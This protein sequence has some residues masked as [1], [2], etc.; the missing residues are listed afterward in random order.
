M[1]LLRGW[2]LI[3]VTC[4]SAVSAHV[5]AQAADGGAQDYA[6]VI[7]DALREFD[8]GHYEEARALFLRANELQPSART[9]RALGFCEFELRHYVAADRWLRA[10]SADQRNPLTSEQRSDVERTLERIR[11]FV[12]R[13]HVQCDPASAKLELDGQSVTL[14]ADGSLLLEVGEHV[15]TASA[16]EHAS[17]T[18]HIDVRGGEDTTLRI[19]L[20]RR[21]DTTAGTTA[22]AA[23][24][25]SS[26]RS[27]V[28]PWSLVIGGGALT[29]GG[30][31]LFALGRAA[32]SDVENAKDGA[33]YASI[34]DAQSRA[35]VLSNLGIALIGVGL[36]AA[37]AG[38]V[39][40]ALRKPA[41]G[42]HPAPAASV[43]LA[44]GGVGVSGVF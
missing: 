44:P 37:G 40:F 21:A 8:A 42:E 20:T 4:V 12:G 18:E 39:L 27:S 16:P 14:D 22:S 24:A 41:D 33:T 10:A 35:P 15:W 25:K 34:R 9:M 29:A 1:R 19:A 13:Y 2:L 26:G 11:T 7:S 43:A 32:A 5:A 3:S 17:V 38:V 36:A 23:P 28:L 6:H 31:V 30:V